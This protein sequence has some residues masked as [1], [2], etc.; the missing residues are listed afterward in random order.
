MNVT[1]L[2]DSQRKHLPKVRI[3]L[4]TTAFDVLKQVARL[5]ETEPKRLYMGTFHAAI[6]NT[7]QPADSA[8][9]CGTVGCLSGWSG[10]V[11]DLNGVSWS[12]TDPVVKALG[13]S[14]NQVRE[15]FFPTELVYGDESRS[16]IGPRKHAAL[17][18]EHLRNFIT[19]NQAQLKAK[20]ITKTELDNLRAEQ[21]EFSL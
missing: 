6:Q 19:L 8:P 21:G 10:F 11:L 17:A 1:A 12:Q 16:V 4:P 2:T 15:L 5:V 9:K 13:L 20:Q 18:L 7:N 3:Q 14:Y